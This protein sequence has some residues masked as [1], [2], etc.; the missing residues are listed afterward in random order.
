MIG[1]RIALAIA[2][3]VLGVGLAVTPASVSMAKCKCSHKKAL[4]KKAYTKAF[5]CKKVPRASKKTCKTAV[6]AAILANCSSCTT[7]CSSPS[8][9][10]ID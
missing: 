2:T 10:F 1:K 8:P 9:A 7:P 3:V 4:C 5:D 6:K